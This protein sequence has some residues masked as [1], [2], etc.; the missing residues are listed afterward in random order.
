ATQSDLE[1]LNSF[2]DSTENGF[3]WYVS[4]KKEDSASLT[5]ILEEASKF[6]QDLPDSLHCKK[7]LIDF[8]E[9]EKVNKNIQT[10]VPDYGK[11]E[12]AARP[13]KPEKPAKP[14]KPKSRILTDI[15]DKEPVNTESDR[16]YSL[17]IQ[18]I[19]ILELYETL[20]QPR[21]SRKNEDLL[22]LCRSIYLRGYDPCYPIAAYEKDGKLYVAN[23]EGRFVAAWLVCYAEEQ[24]TEYTETPIDYYRALREKAPLEKG[25]KIPVRVIAEYSSIESFL[26][27][28]NRADFTPLEENIFLADR[29]DYWTET[30]A[31]FPKSKARIS[32]ITKTIQELSTVKRISDK[33]IA[34][35]CETKQETIYTESAKT[36]STAF[37]L[38]ALE[39]NTH[40]GKIW[41]AHL[42]QLGRIICKEFKKE[43]LVTD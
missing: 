5:E 8:V 32:K 36:L 2:G 37:Y 13:A 39:C 17:G 24:K 33:K 20:D 14:K 43:S 25:I 19:N 15:E 41:D 12:N 40:T 28:K 10:F 27:N 34:A 3:I 26:D 38:A 9:S 21:Q 23:G 42:T 29:L 31:K 1:I 22:D 18:D 16:K 6:T 35:I 4:E 7:A 11:S 30:T